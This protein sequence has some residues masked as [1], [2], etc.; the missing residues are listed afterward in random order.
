ML[1]QDIRWQ[2]PTQKTVLLQEGKPIGYAQLTVTNVSQLLPNQGVA[3]QAN[4]AIMQ[5]ETQGNIR[6]RDD[7]VAP[8]STV[9]MPLYAGNAVEFDTDQSINNVQ[10]IL[11]SDTSSNV[12]LNISYYQKG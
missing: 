7:G 5:I 9:G 10:V 1:S 12:T 2:D 4:K 8:T 6:W 3:Q 11:S